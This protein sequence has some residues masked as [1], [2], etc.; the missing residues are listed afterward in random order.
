MNDTATIESPATAPLDEGWD[1]AFVE[2]MGH[3][4]HW[5]RI[6]EEERFGTK[7]MRVDVPTVTETLEVEVDQPTTQIIWSTHFYT[8]S[9]IFSLTLTDEATVMKRNTPYR[10]PYR[11]TQRP[12]MKEVEMHQPEPASGS[13]DDFEANEDDD[14]N[15]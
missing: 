2:I 3:R 13:D 1:W 11:L 10:P 4:S 14:L 15:F 7:M 9:S 8:G 6:R 12:E 5:G